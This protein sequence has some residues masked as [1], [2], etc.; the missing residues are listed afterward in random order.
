MVPYTRLVVTPGIDP[1]EVTYIE[2]DMVS[3]STIT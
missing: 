2:T 1:G 3:G